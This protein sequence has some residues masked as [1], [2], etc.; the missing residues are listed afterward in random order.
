MCLL[1]LQN[2]NQNLHEKKKIIIFKEWFQCN[3]YSIFTFEYLT[4]F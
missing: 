2:T 3:Q 1:S 4:L